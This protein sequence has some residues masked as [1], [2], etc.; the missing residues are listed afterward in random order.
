[1]LIKNRHVKP[2]W[3]SM[4]AL[5]IPAH[6]EVDSHPKEWSF[7]VYMMPLRDFELER[8]FRSGAA[9][10]VNSCRC[11]LPLHGIFWMYHVNKYMYRATM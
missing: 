3:K 8:N 7:L 10:R 6:R 9:T 2:N 11:E 1:M 5:A 4:H